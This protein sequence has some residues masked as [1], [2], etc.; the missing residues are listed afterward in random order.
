MA[1]A[2]LHSGW[3]YF[4]LGIFVGA[5]F[6]YLLFAVLSAGHRADEAERIERRIDQASR[7]GHNQ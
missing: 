6:A 3:L 1:E 7:G 5:N 2:I 4:T